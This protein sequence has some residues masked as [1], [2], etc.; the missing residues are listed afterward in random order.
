MCQCIKDCICLLWAFIDSNV[1]QNVIL[2]FTVW[3]TWRI[4]MQANYQK[5]KDAATSIVLQI[6][7]IY[8]RIFEIDKICNVV[9][10]E[11]KLKKTY[12][13]I[14]KIWSMTKVFEDNYWSA[15]CQHFTKHLLS[16]N[17]RIINDFYEKATTINSQIDAF[18]D[19]IHSIYKSFYVEKKEEKT[20]AEDVPYV[21][22]S[23]TYTNVFQSSIDELKEIYKTDAFA[24][25][26]EILK[27]IVNSDYRTWRKLKCQK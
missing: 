4:Y 14:S 16:N 9:I 23:A 10:E 27:K 3:L 6:Q 24:N 19:M 5:E 17:I 22:A 20:I 18:H 26:I 12:F 11:N 8:E 13:N 7:S 15:Y 21:R 25:S 2:V 1:V